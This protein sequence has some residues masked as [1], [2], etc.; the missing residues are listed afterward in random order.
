[1]YAQLC[2]RPGVVYII[3]MLGR[4]LYNPRIDHWKEIKQV[5]W[6]FQRAKDYMLTYKTLEHLEIVKYF[7]PD[8]ASYQE[9][10]RFTL[11]YIYLLSKGAISWKNAKQK[12]IASSTLI[13]EFILQ[14]VM[15]HPIIIYGCKL[16]IVFKDR[17]DSL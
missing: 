8:F 7:D 15:K 12:L 13:V 10:K 1:M 9:R 14:H 17:E 5:M 11:G 16:Q 2:T 6:Y 3:E 4:Y